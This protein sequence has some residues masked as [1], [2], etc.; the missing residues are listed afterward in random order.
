MLCSSA[1][2]PY[3]CEICGRS[4]KYSE[5][6]AHHRKVHSGATR[7]A[8]CGRVCSKVAA[9]RLH[10]RNKHRL[11]AEQVRAMVPT[12]ERNQPMEPWQM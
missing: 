4:Y 10:L 2:P 6:L 12:R 1:G 5:S 8:L 7:C 9:L 3:R 11:T